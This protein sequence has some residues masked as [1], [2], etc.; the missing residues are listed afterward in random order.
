MAGRCEEGP[1]GCRKARAGIF[2]NGEVLA[3]VDS[4][5]TGRRGAMD[6]AEA[7][8]VKLVAD[9]KRTTGTGAVQATAVATRLARRQTDTQ[10]RE[11]VP[12]AKRS[13]WP[14]HGGQWRGSLHVGWRGGCV[15]GR[16][17]LI[18]PSKA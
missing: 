14:V 10:V 5:R 13:C 18:R 15:R 1:T 6:G 11:K 3:Q 4:Q 16:R 2:A 7:L 9:A 12:L 8:L 17:E